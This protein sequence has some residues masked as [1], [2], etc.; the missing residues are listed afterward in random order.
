MEVFNVPEVATYLNC[1]CSA[2]RRLV[3]T[4]GIPYFRV[5]KRII[6]Q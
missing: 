5:G 2:I 1:S 4:N 3:S 6:M